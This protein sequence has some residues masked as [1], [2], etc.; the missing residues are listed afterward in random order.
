MEN[1]EDESI[2]ELQRKVNYYNQKLY[3]LIIIGC[4]SQL[5][6]FYLYSYY[7]S[8]PFI[9]IAIP[10]FMIAMISLVRFY[11]LSNE[12]LPVKIK[13]NNIIS[14]YNHISE[15]D[16]KI[17]KIQ[18]WEC[19]AIVGVIILYNSTAIFNI[20]SSRGELQ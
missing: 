18:N 15:N 19:I 14:K 13:H 6:G 11:F 4:L 5:I 9:L 1:N 20:I 16:Q 12:A 7:N 2:E 3:R 10:S 17:I 8:Y